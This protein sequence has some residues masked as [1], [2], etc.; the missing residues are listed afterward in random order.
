MSRYLCCHVIIL[1]NRGLFCQTDV[2]SGNKRLKCPFMIPLQSVYA[3]KPRQR[4]DIFF[5]LCHFYSLSICLI[6]T[7]F[8][9]LGAKLHFR[10]HKLSA[11][12]HALFLNKLCQIFERHW[13][14]CALYL[15]H[16]LSGILPKYESVAYRQVTRAK[17]TIWN[18]DPLT[19]CQTHT[20]K[21]HTRLQYKP[22]L[23]LF[24][25]Y[26]CPVTLILYS[27]ESD[28]I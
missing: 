2:V 3:Y 9:F 28:R 5:K 17:N 18:R 14:K 8:R 15:T 4:D 6:I 12:C 11:F 7:V 21:K 16:F 26:L 23:I 10:F 13:T 19:K 1:K 25:Q 24:T 20:V 22:V 27:N